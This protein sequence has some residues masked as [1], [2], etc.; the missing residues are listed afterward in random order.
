[1]SK[2]LLP[3]LA[4]V[5]SLGLASGCNLIYKQNIQQGNALEQEDLDQLRLGMTMNQ[6]AYLLGTPAIQDPFHHD[7]WDYLSSYSRRGGEPTR[8]TVTLLFENSQL[9]SMSGVKLDGAGPDDTTSA[10]TAETETPLEPEA[11]LEEAP[12]AEPELTPVEAPT[13]VATSFESPAPTAAEAEEALG[14]E[15]AAAT[16]VPEAEIPDPSPQEPVTQAET[17]AAAVVDGWSIQLGAFDS[18]EN[19]RRILERLAEAGYPAVISTRDAGLSGVR[20]LVRQHGIATR[21]DALDVLQSIEDELGIT[22]FLVP[23]VP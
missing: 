15:A 3:L 19:A 20:Y 22:G 7:R 9:V 10:A 17:P 1:M 13:A 4:L 16:A 21:D 11:V 23:P 12:A 2:R 18:E 8:R 5:L 6:V 14:T